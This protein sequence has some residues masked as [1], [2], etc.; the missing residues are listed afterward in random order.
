M[1]KVKATT[2]YKVTSFINDDV[3]LFNTKNEVEEYIDSEL[4]FANVHERT[5]PYTEDDFAVREIFGFIHNG[6][7]FSKEDDG[8][9]RVFN[10]KKDKYFNLHFQ[11]IDDAIDFVKKF[12][13]IK[14]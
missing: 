12:S 4:R 13:L 11:T 8:Y 6:F 5:N 9:F 14:K 10:L 3:E 7:E 1:K 2:V